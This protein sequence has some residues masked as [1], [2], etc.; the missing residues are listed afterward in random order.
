MSVDATN[1]EAAAYSTDQQPKDEHS[2][3]D[4]DTIHP[5]FHWL[6]IFP[7]ETTGGMFKLAIVVSPTPTRPRFSQHFNNN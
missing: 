5:K 7:S 3:D 6:L 1:V 2:N 4:S